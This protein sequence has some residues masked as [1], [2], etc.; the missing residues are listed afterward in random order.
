MELTRGI[1]REEIVFGQL[2]FTVKFGYFG[3]D[4]VRLGVHQTAEG[5][6]SRADAANWE[7]SQPRFPVVHR[8]RARKERTYKFPA[9]TLRS[10]SQNNSPLNQ[11][12]VISTLMQSK[13]ALMLEF[14][15]CFAASAVASE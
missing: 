2:L 12:L 13:V 7:L 10:S 15:I 4:E 3:T 14:A 11:L 5:N 6:G 8:I 1:H 9:A